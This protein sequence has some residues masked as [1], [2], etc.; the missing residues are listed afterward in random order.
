MANIKQIIKEQFKKNPV[1]TT[2]MP[3]LAF[4]SFM[5]LIKPARAEHFALML[6]FNLMFWTSFVLLVFITLYIIRK[7]KPNFLKKIF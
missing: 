7:L 5:N 1:T 3:L 6:G 2:L 4:F